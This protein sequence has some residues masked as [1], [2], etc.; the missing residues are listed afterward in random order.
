MLSFYPLYDT[1][2]KCKSRSWQKSPLKR[3]RKA[4]SGKWQNPLAWPDTTEPGVCSLA[5][6][7]R[8]QQ[9]AVSNLAK[10]SGVLSPLL[11]QSPA[12]WLCLPVQ[13]MSGTQISTVKSQCLDKQ[14]QLGQNKFFLAIVWLNQKQFSDIASQLKQQKYAS[15]FS[16]KQGTKGPSS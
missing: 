10:I 3:L 2:I 6:A 5:Q 13:C 7:P 15:I 12:T 11:L 9:R 1:K 14:M 4:Q 8:C 16:E